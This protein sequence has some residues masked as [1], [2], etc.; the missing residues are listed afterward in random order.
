MEA[1]SG[2]MKML[3][4]PAPPNCATAGA[5]YWSPIRRFRSSSL[6]NSQLGG[7]ITS[8]TYLAAGR[9]AGNAPI[10]AAPV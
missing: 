4:K 3:P 8:V 5:M 7:T 9:I 6:F 2:V 1:W 10:P